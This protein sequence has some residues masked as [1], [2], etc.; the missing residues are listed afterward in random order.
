MEAAA[1]GHLRARFFSLAPP[2]LA[3]LFAW[4]AAGRLLRPF[5][6][7]APVAM[8]V[9]LSSVLVYLAFHLG[10]F[11]ALQQPLAATATM[12]PWLATLPGAMVGWVLILVVASIRLLW[13]RAAADLQ[14]ARQ[15]HDGDPR[16]RP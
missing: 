11:L 3:F 6:S 14:A 15:A 9:T 13:G 5:R 4:R 8:E 2:L 12:S 1:D 16:Q 10:L 7:F